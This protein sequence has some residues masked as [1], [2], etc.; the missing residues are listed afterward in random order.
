MHVSILPLFLHRWL[1]RKSSQ[2]Q[3]KR[4]LK[5]LEFNSGVRRARSFRN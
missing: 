1:F 3:N 5:T 4:S 2:V